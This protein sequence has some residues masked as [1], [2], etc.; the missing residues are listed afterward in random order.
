[1]SFEELIPVGRDG[2][3]ADVAGISAIHMPASTPTLPILI[4]AARPSASS[5]W[6]LCSK[7]RTRWRCRRSRPLHTATAGIEDD[8]QC[9]VDIEALVRFKLSEIARVGDHLVGI[10]DAD[11]QR[12]SSM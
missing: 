7:R 8:A 3:L 6:L 1:M 12:G 10:G 11:V 5:H 9:V 2:R 4:R